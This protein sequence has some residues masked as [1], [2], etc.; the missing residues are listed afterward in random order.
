MKKVII[1]V[2]RWIS[3]PAAAFVVLF[4]PA[5]RAIDV[6]GNFFFGLKKESDE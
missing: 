5:G 6:V 4:R 2:L 1:T 3:W